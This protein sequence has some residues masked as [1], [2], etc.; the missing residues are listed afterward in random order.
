MNDASGNG[1]LWYEDGVLPLSAIYKYKGTFSRFTLYSKLDKFYKLNL[2]K[3]H[4]LYFA[5]PNNLSYFFRD[6][7]TED[8]KN[9]M[10]QITKG[11]FN[12]LV[13]KPFKIYHPHL[14]KYVLGLTDINHVSNLMNERVIY[15]LSG[16]HYFVLTEDNAELAVPRSDPQRKLKIGLLLDEIRE[17]YKKFR[18]WKP[19]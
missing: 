13:G 10:M 7:Q 14:L 3:N 2:S 19:E 9:S 5:T 17:E 18:E 6:V 8:Y 1:K 12:D 4:V 15:V 11:K 16:T